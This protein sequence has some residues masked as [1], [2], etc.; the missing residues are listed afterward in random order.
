MTAGHKV[1]ARLRRPCRRVQPHRS[2]P[3]ARIGPPS[4]SVA[5]LA[6]SAT[7]GCYTTSRTAPASS[8]RVVAWRG[9]VA[10]RRNLGTRPCCARTS[11]ARRSGAS[12]CTMGAPGGR[13]GWAGDP[14]PPGAPAPAG[15]PA[16]P[17]DPGPAGVA[18]NPRPV[19]GAG[20]P[21]RTPI[22]QSPQALPRTSQ[23]SQSTI[24]SAPRVGIVLGPAEGR[25][26]HRQSRR[27]GESEPVHP[28]DAA[29]SRTA[30]RRTYDRT[31]RPSNTADGTA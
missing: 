30:T 4:G 26:T 24:T 28:G 15:A 10:T 18:G 14:A 5:T 1:P 8:P 19:S 20:T 12:S 7:P 27:S 21:S 22:T 23:L 2:R 11:R 31:S 6:G 9:C 3:V 29:G 13:P 17:G 25:S 16:P